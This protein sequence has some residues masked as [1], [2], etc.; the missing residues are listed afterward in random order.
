ML[1][2]EVSLV[3]SLSLLLGF[4]CQLCVFGLGLC[5]YLCNMGVAFVGAWLQ[6]CRVGGWFSYK[7]LVRLERLFIVGVVSVVFE[8]VGFEKKLKF[9][10]D[11]WYGAA[12]CCSVGQ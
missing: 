10:F 8:L 1:S 12:C 11:W 4:C 9:D 3:V 2:I 5:N 6:V 7:K